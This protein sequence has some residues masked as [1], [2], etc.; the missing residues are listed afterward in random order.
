MKCIVAIILIAV[1]ASSAHAQGG[2]GISNPL[3]LS[4]DGRHEL[5]ITF[6]AFR[7]T[8]TFNLRRTTGF[9]SH[10]RFGRTGYIFAL[11]YLRNLNHSLAVGGEWAYIS[12]EQQEITNVYNPA[13]PYVTRV[14][15]DT[16]LVL[17]IVRLRAAGAGLR[18]YV[19]GG[20]GWYRTRLNVYGA[21]PNGGPEADFILDAKTGFAWMT[22]AGVEY[23]TALGSFIALE[24]GYL[25]TGAKSFGATPDGVVS[26]FLPVS[27]TS[28]GMMLSMRVGTRFGIPTKQ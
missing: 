3:A 17:G 25:R 22:R 15:G 4:A 16:N 6:G 23:A 8:A 9:N 2:F 12:R 10:D 28:D 27:S 18:P 26:G 24:G 13:L 21:W 14:R 19:I 20:A 1:A 11:D 7:P 5:G